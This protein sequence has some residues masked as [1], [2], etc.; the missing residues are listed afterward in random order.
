MAAFMNT[1][2]RNEEGLRAADGSESPLP[3]FPLP[4]Q[5]GAAPVNILVVDDLAEKHLVFRSILEDLGQNVISAYSGRE[6]LRAVLEDEFAVILL[7]VNMP[8]MDGFETAGLIRNYK[9]TAQT[10]IVFIT[11]YVDEVQAVRGY[12]LGAVDYISSPVVPEI[13]RSKVKVFVDLHRLNRELR[14]QAQAREA[15]AHAEA[16]RCAAEAATRRADLLAAASQTLSRSLD[17]DATIGG[18]LGFAAPGLA[19]CAMVALV[20]DR[21]ELARLRLADDYGGAVPDNQVSGEIQTQELNAIVARALSIRE[22]LRLPG[23]I[24]FTGAPAG[25]RPL[26]PVHEAAVFPMHVGERAF[27]ALI[28]GVCAPRKLDAAEMALAKEVVSRAVIALE[29]ASL[30]A[31]IQEAD[32]RKNEFLA[33]LAHELR[34]PLAPIRNAVH[35]LQRGGITE[36]NVTWS[37]EVIGRQVDH[38]ATLVDDLLDVSRIARGK[39]VVARDPLR[40]NEVIEHALETS[41]PVLE[42]RRHHLVVQVPREE[43]SFNGD[44]VRLAQVLSNLLNNAAKFTPPGGHITLEAAVVGAELRIHVRDNGAGIEPQLLPHVF[45]LFTQGDQTLDRSEGGLGIGLTLVKHLIELHG[46]RVQ[47]RSEG[48]GT[49]AE[50]ILTL[51]GV[52]VE[53]TGPA[54]EEAPAQ[55]NAAR[56]VARVLV[57]DDV[58]ASAESLSRL[59]EIEGHRVAVAGDG[60]GAISAAASFRPDVVVLDIGLPGKNG[61]EVAAE[62]RASGMHDDTLL[63]ALSGYGGAEDRERGARAGFSHYLVK[64][65]DIPTLL[66]IIGAH[67]ALRQISERSL[68]QGARN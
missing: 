44:L 2:G 23:P 29:N 1:P 28:L 4:G 13:L 14:Q 11:A 41:R 64:P 32:R 66:S 68:A 3:E 51:P 6:A 10:P 65:A 17:M 52:S 56:K 43:V 59:L 7:D 35:V 63:I 39:V 36:K 58:Q 24:G 22:T 60:E 12:A 50:F 61:F 21:G 47:A 55:E 48:R 31:A 45:D 33:M 49:G 26:V 18:L 5:E 46:G 67:A 30:Y 9:K 27:G 8:D 37:S 19:D 62:L 16:A 40:L 25:T 20:D 38:L 42:K 57:V 54:T 53:T 34:N 15:L